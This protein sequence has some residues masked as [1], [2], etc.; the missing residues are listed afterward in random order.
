[1]DLSPALRIIGKYP[2]SLEG[3]AVGIL[4][5]DGADGALVKQVTKAAEV[6]GATVKIVAPKIGGVKLKDGT[7]LKADGQLAGTPSVVFDAVALVLSKVGCETLVKDS[8]AIDFVSNAF[9]HL[10]AIGFTAEAQPLLDRVGVAPDAAVVDLGDGAEAF[11]EPA[12]TRQW[13]REPKVR[14]LA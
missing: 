14:M 10:K 1:M 13:A 7:L 6:G 8:A 3:R 4:V 9:A 11:I 5:T 2:D 12:K